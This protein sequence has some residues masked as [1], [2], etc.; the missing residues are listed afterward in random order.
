VIRPHVA[1]VGAGITGLT[2]AYR[3]VRAMGENA[4]VAVFESNE[5][6]GG[7]IRTIEVGGVRV[8]AGADS[9][10]VRKPWAVDLCNEL[11]LEDRLVVP[12]ATGAYVWT[13]GKLRPFPQRSA[14]GIPS[15]VVDL[16]RWGGIP[17]PA[18]LRGALDLYRPARHGD[19]DEPLG[20]L[21]RRRLGRRAAEVMVEPL[22]AGLHAGDPDQLGARATFPELADWERR[23]GSLIRGARAALKA[24]PRGAPMFATVWGGLDGLVDA[25][26]SRLGPERLRLGTAVLGIRAEGGRYRLQT[27]STEVDAD[28]VILTQPAFGSSRL[29]ASVNAEAARGLASIPYAST[30]VVILVYPEG[31][32]NRLPAGTGFVTPIGPG[33]ITA[34][35]W[36]SRKW[37]SDELG[38]RAVVR[39]FVGR[40]GSEEALELP[41]HRL[42][43]E[44]RAES[45]AAVP[46]P[47]APE[48][49]EV[50]RWPDAMPQYEVGHAERVEG[51]DRALLA[52]PGIFVSG[53]AY[54]GVGI[55]DCVRQAG[56]A[57]GK[58]TEFLG[59]M[60]RTA[61]PE[62]TDEREAIGWTT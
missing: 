3:V 29:L 34:C 18:R 13:G 58:V 54:R 15:H 47:G 46:M 62:Q 57:A 56:E 10:V 28:S 43:D 53:S 11:G 52:T 2:A 5:Q 39:C 49:T 42:V 41:D 21:L 12:G 4:Q 25:L 44:V 6:P 14:F 1:V 17:V 51:I 48:A 20:Q 59:G 26:A 23:H 27:D 9:F 19:T 32:V 60:G 16:L 40:A 36:I 35:T 30:A 31:T 22:L 8:E 38:S 24:G 55:A 45:E 33:T 7:K 50:I 61:E 37:A